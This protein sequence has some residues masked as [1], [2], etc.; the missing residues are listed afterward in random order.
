[1]TQVATGWLGGISKHAKCCLCDTTDAYL[2]K[3]K[4]MSFEI[5]KH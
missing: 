4:P 3:S 5:L 2:N 1:M